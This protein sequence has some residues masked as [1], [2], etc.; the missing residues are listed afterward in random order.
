[1]KP[2]WPSTWRCDLLLL[3][4]ALQ[5]PSPLAQRF[6]PDSVL[7]AQE[8]LHHDVQIAFGDSGTH[9][10]AQVRTSWLLRS[11]APLEIQLDTAFRVIRVLSD[12]TGPPGGG[13]SRA[14]YAIEARGIYLPHE[15]HAGDTL[16]TVVRYHGT[17]RDG[18]RF[19]D[20]TVHGR[21]AFADNWPDRAHFWIPLQDHASA[22]ASV[23][24]HVEVPPGM[25]ALA[26]GRLVRVDTLAY[27]RTVWSFRQR[28]PVPPYGMVVGVGH[29]ATTPLP[30]AACEVRCVP[31]SVVTFPHDS[32]WAVNGPFH[33]VGDIVD[34][35][36]RLVGPFPYD[37]LTQV[38]ANTIYGGMEN[39]T[40][41]FYA[42]DEYERRRLDES[43]VAHETAH[44]WF[45]DAVT[46]RDWRHVWLSEGFATYLAALWEEH[47]GG[48]IALRDAMRRAAERIFASPSTEHPMLAYLTDSLT[49]QLNTN[50]YEKGSWVLHSL[51]GVVGDSAFF[52]GLRRYYREYRDSTALSSDFARVMEAAAG[53]DLEW[54][55]LQALT[56]PG[57][58]RLE[59]S[60]S[61]QGRRMTLA[62]RQVQPASWGIYRL[63]GLTLQVDDRR[64]HT[65]VTAPETVITLEDV[66][67]D[68]G[69]IVIDPD[70][71]WLLQATVKPGR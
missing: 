59:V 13:M 17:P 23:D 21:S 29:F 56:R 32:A 8:A 40:A 10:V 60:W 45:G 19:A 69:R 36:S 15:R 11:A 37:Q 4:L 25:E 46:E 42:V 51:R 57:Y 18:L 55:F 44:Q 48:E 31:Q 58:P 26:T 49:S 62:I 70:G 22:K 24:W 6:D 28:Q 34:W 14:L 5:S 64:V 50:S 47:V 16:V 12:G 43:L 68:P 33:R 71:W 1:M 41:I 38:E 20:D 9:I 63:P 66:A 53:Q 3:F 65:D 27:G 67:R 54:Y 7:P 2:G 52:E 39:P 61:R 35:F 30:D